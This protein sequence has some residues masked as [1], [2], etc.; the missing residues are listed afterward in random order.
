[1]GFRQ[2]LANCP[3]SRSSWLLTTTWN[4]SQR[5]CAGNRR[6]NMMIEGAVIAEPP[7]KLVSFSLCNARLFV[8]HLLIL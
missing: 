8:A 1:M 3:A 5:D 7:V 2:A 6:T 4:L